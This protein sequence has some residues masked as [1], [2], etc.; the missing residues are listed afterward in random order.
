MWKILETADNKVL[1]VC[2]KSSH[3]LQKATGLTN[4]FVAKMGV[5]ITSL[6]LT[7]DIVNFLHQFLPYKTPTSGLVLD[8]LCFLNMISNSIDCTKA[9]DR[10]DDIKPSFLF[11]YRNRYNRFLWWGFLIFDSIRFYFSHQYNFLNFAR[12][13][14]FSVGLLIFY[15]FIAVDPLPPGKSKIREWIESFEKVLKPALQQN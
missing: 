8:G 12:T 4:Y 7:V 5:G 13:E 2:T 14:F 9:E 11:R 1:E 6:S 3:K 10:L 15:Y